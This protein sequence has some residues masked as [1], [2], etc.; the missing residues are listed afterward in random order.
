[1]IH[2]DNPTYNV[3]LNQ[4]AQWGEELPSLREKFDKPLRVLSFICYQLAS[5][6]IQEGMLPFEYTQ[7]THGYKHIIQLKGSYPKGWALLHYD[8]HKVL[9]QLTTKRWLCVTE[10]Q[11]ATA[12]FYLHIAKFG[13]NPF[14]PIVYHHHSVGGLC[15]FEISAIDFPVDNPQCPV[16]AKTW[17]QVLHSH[18]LEDDFL[19]WTPDASE[20][21]L[22]SPLAVAQFS[23]A[24]A[25][26]Q[27]CLIND[28]DIYL[29]LRAKNVGVCKSGQFV[30]STILTN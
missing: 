21:I 14:F 28:S 30:I 11:S 19:A 4:I 13:N 17:W 3:L 5:K 16:V 22:A 10:Q 18:C 20:N 26:I 7:Y 6:H 27:T 29:D 1:M 25:A 8:E 23:E 9:F 2:L 24:I 15:Y 12:K